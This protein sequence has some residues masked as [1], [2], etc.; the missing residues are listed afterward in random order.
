[1]TFTGTEALMLAWAAATI[2]ALLG[3]LVMALVVVG[4]RGD[5]E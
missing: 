2:G 5:E 1:M 4:K 3:V